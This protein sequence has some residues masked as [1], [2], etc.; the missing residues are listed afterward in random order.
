VE[1]W[2]ECLLIAGEVNKFNVSRR[3]RLG[4]ARYLVSK[5]L[6]HSREVSMLWG[7][8]MRTGK[9]MGM[10]MGLHHCIAVDIGVGRE[11]R[12]HCSVGS[13]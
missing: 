11:E 3:A 2:L 12:M 13:C 4:S 9:E 5:D 1:S 6:Y 7:S 8:F 10:G